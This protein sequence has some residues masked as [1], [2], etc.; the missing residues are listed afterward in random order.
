VLLVTAFASVE[1]AVDAMKLGA[2]D[3]LRKPMRED[4]DVAARWELD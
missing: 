1:L 2:T 4:L 3:F